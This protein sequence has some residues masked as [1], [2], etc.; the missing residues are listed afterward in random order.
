MEKFSMN[1][2]GLYC[3]SYFAFGSLIPLL[4]QYLVS[5][6]LNG[7]EIGTITALGLLAGVFTTPLW[8]MVCDRTG[9]NKTILILLLIAP[10]TLSLVMISLQ[11]YYLILFNYTVFYIFQNS[12]TPVMDSL[13]LNF[14][15]DFG[16]IRLWGA[17]G[18]AVGV[19]FSGFIAQHF[20]LHTIFIIYSS[21]V[22]IAVLFLRAIQ[23]KK[24]ETT[25]THFEGIST[26]VSNKKYLLFI[27]A[28]FFV[29]G[30]ILAHNTYFG[31]LYTH[32]GGT[33]AGVGIAFFL[34]CIS[35]APMMHFVD[36]IEKRFSIEN[37]IILAIVLS[38]I[39]WFWY[40][41]GPSP[42]LLLG[43]FFL[44]GIVNGIFLIIAIKYISAITRKETRSTAIAIYSSVCSGVGT[45]V[46]QYLGGIILDSSGPEAIYL[47]YFFFNIV[48]FIL[49]ILFKILKTRFE[50]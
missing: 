42:A 26:L 43:T 3:C 38:M 27:A 21:F 20:G 25:F 33:I 32:L 36:Q 50:K 24:V 23:T 12:I 28:A 31:I 10:A 40:S 47:A 1:Y 9:K 15:S 19:V 6:G 16:K 39:R 30:P 45:M 7:V 29:Q 4:S 44:Q 49:F 11:N 41:T 13:A 35:E 34:F 22:C 48:A 5:I 2:I 46:C 37:I 17:V 8:G 18:Y 14:S